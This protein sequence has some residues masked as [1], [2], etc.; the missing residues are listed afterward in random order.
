ML[1]HTVPQ[2]HSEEI[3]GRELSVINLEKLARTEVDHISYQVAVLG[4]ETQA[5]QSVTCR[6]T[7]LD[8]TRHSGIY[9]LTVKRTSEP[10]GTN[11]PVLVTLFFQP[12]RLQKNGKVKV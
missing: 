6:D 8:S 12:M 5:F 4:T 9:V 1:K 11:Q 10:C 3:H 7:V 2:Y